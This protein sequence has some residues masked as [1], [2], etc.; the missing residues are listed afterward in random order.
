MC[1]SRMRMMTMND[2]ELDEMLRGIPAPRA[3]QER[4]KA[5]KVPV[6]ELLLFTLM[7]LA[8]LSWV[9]GARAGI[10]GP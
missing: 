7:A 3:P 8:L 10:F 5:K 4:A 2:D 9:L 1:D 6:M